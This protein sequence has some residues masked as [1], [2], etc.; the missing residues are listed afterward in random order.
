MAAGQQLSPVW[1]MGSTST[2][3]PLEL[4]GCD[5]IELAPRVRHARATSSS[6]TT[7]APARA[8]S[9]TAFAAQHGRLRGA[10]R[11][12]GVPVHRGLPRARR[13]RDRLRR[14]LRRRAGG[15]LRGGFDP[16]R[17]HLHGNAKT[18]GRAARGLARASARSSSTTSTTS[19]RLEPIFA[20]GGRRRP[21]R[22][23]PDRAGRRARHASGDLDRRAEHEVR[24]QPAGGAEAIARRAGRR[25]A[26]TSTA[27]TSTSARRSSTCSR[28]APRWSRRR[29]SWATSATFNLGGGLGVAYTRRSA[30]AVDRGL[31]RREGRAGRRALRARQAHRRRARAR[32]DRELGVTLYTVQSVKHNVATWVAVDGGMSD[33]LRPM[34]YDAHYEVES[35]AASAAAR[36]ATSSA[37]TASRGD[38]LVARRRPA[39]PRSRGHDRDP[40]HRGVRS[41]DGQQLQRRA[42]AA[43]RVRAGRRRAVSS[44]AA[45]PTRTSSAV[46]L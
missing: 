40:G 20:G 12:Q 34:L 5:A 14:R 4:G 10:L 44:C 29:A 18:R 39:D 27:C 25:H 37:S 41:R 11:L 2:P 30:P 36:R 6:R 45:R 17:I 13:G 21:A 35:P 8:R 43:G 26:S 32:P 1:P 3:R 16:A 19:T 28:S 42:A 24:L 38:V 23:D 46:M 15:A 9:S 31:R 33:N 22:P 7:C